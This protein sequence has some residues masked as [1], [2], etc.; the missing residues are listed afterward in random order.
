VRPRLVA[1]V[2][3]AAVTTLVAAAQ[4]PAT[5]APTPVV[6]IKITL[7]DT[8]IRVSPK[9]AQRGTVARFLLTNV[10]RKPHKFT[11]GHL[12]H[13]SGT[14]TGFTRSLT[15][16][17]QSI[18]LLFLDYRGAIPYQGTLPGDRT[19]PGMKGTFTIF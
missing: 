13:G 16:N 11:F 8:V 5:T 2:L 4:S 12:R 6:N 19:R 10:G 17:Q 1:L 9:R 14:Q 18:L 7:T 15:P 3:I